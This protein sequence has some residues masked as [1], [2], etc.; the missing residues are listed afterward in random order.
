MNMYRFAILVVLAAAVVVS[1]GAE[2]PVTL[3]PADQRNAVVSGNVVAWEDHRN[4]NWDI[5]MKNLDTNAETQVSSSV[6]DETN[7]DI[8]RSRIVYQ[9]G[10]GDILLY[11]IGSGAT[12]T[13]VA[14]PGEQSH[15]RISGDWVVWQDHR[16]SDWDVYFYNLG[17][18]VESLMTDIGDQYSPSVDGNQMT[19]V[20]QGASTGET[21]IFVYDAASVSTFLI[22]ATGHPSAPDIGGGAV[23]Y[24]GWDTGDQKVYRRGITGGT[25]RA[26][27]VGGGDHRSQRIDGA[28]V[29]FTADG[30]GSEIWVYSMNFDTGTQITSNGVDVADQNPAIDGT[31]VVWE[32]N[33]NG[34]WDI[35]TE[36]VDQAFIGPITSPIV[37]IRTLPTD[38]IATSLTVVQPVGT[39]D[40][41]VVSPASRFGQRRYVVGS[42][43]LNPP[44]GIS[45][46]AGRTIATGTRTRSVIGTGTATGLTPPATRFVRWSPLTRWWSGVK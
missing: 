10:V 31:R 4:G 6:E 41:G 23:T 27:P 33:R 42:V 36:S 39:V 28:R 40:P 34:N 37:P 38:T 21:F 43:P 45:G 14:V 9:F 15:P 44:T 25:P 16:G 22:T 18:G 13:V 32:T 46:G 8:D 24:L 1:V 26:V 20:S 30:A 35:Y 29:A 2:T 11:D 5:Y 3:N 19:W 17:T 7:P 12:S